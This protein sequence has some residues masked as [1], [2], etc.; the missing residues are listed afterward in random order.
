VARRR[1]SDDTTTSEWT[2]LSSL[3]GLA[4]RDAAGLCW[5]V[6]GLGLWS[7]RSIAVLLSWTS[8]F[9]YNDNPSYFKKL[10][11]RWRI[12][13]QIQALAD[14]ACCHTKHSRSPSLSAIRINSHRASTGPSPFYIFASA[15]GLCSF[16]RRYVSPFKSLVTVRRSGVGRS[17]LNLD[18]QL[19][20]TRLLFPHFR[21]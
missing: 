2:S 10:P 4:W 15:I 3:G 13:P 20:K 9:R 8:R 11:S 19:V 17:Y 18:T 16:V 7:R 6:K 12:A 14:A 1:A 21:F 5:Y